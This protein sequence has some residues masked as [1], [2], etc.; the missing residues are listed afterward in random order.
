MQ[1]T[2]PTF[3][4]ADRLRNLA[5]L[6]VIIIHVAAPVVEF[7]K[8]FHTTQWWAGN[9]LNS[10]SRSAVPLFVMLSGFLL[11]GKDYPLPD[12]LKRRFTRVLVPAFFWM[13]AYSIYNFQA[14]NKPT[15]WT[16]AIRGII[17]GP[18][19]YHLWFI[20]LIIGL[21]LL[22]PLI[23]PWVRQATERD[24]MF[25]FILCAAGTWLYKILY[26]FGNQLVIG[27]SWESYTN[28]LGYFVLGYYL[29]NKPPAGETP[30][31]PGIRPWPWTRRQ[32]RWIA[33]GLIA[34]G[35][36][37]TALGTFWMSTVYSQKFHPLFY[38]Y[39]TVNCTMMA[40]GWFMLAQLT[41]NGRPLLQ[42]EQEFAAASFGIYLVHVMCM[43]WWSAGGY[44]YGREHPVLSIPIIVL[45]TYLMSFAAVKIIRA[46]PGGER[47]T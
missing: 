15:N 10:A 27:I 36:L 23:R 41:F 16:E 33:L 46:L 32:L 12:F 6:M 47:I 28:H 14:G 9:I 19:H 17:S 18:V 20:Y 45:L 8:D 40:I 11:L 44:W 25:V 24:F 34:L 2:K 21:Y 3:Y 26:N 39:L 31:T 1:Q 42:V 13:I 22:Y 37:I 43:D 30:P 35:T 5:T 38:D 7:Y 4:W 29:G